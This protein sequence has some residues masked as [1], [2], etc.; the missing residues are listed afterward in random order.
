MSGGDET[1]VVEAWIKARLLAASG[2]TSITNRV[3]IEEAPAD[4]QYP[5]IIITNQSAQDV[6]G[7]GTARVMTD[8]LYVVK[9]VYQGADF[10]QGR[11]LAKEI[12]NAL[13]AAGSEAVAGG[14]TMLACVREEPFRLA[15]NDAGKQ[16][17][18]IGGI[19]RIH[20]QGS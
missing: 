2:V 3:F 17:R 1:I 7:V 5:F 18:H 9:A 11:T 15:E 13:T 19:Y 20:A 16:Y 6:R 14:G 8:T 10:S 4:T 12:D